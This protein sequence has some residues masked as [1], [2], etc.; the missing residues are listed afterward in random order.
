MVRGT[1]HGRRLG[2]Q[3][4]GAIAA[5]LARGDSLASIARFLGV[6]VS[7]VSREVAAGACQVFCVSGL[8]RG[9]G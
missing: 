5:G 8:F 7:T 9:G 2:A 4:R 1:G 3:G 6:A